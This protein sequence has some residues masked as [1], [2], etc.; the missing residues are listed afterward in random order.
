MNPRRKPPATA[1]SGWIEQLSQAGGIDLRRAAAL[2]DEA[3][4]FARASGLGSTLVRERDGQL[5][6]I[7][8]SPSQAAK[9]RNLRA[10]LEH[11]LTRAGWP[12]VAVVVKLHPTPRPTVVQP[13]IR[14]Q[15]LPV[16][17]IGEW[18]ALHETL[19][20]GPLKDAVARLLRHRRG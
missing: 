14:P 17:V 13:E 18:A 1:L 7:A 2:Q 10:S 4:R 16:T 8:A 19:E 20:A 5:V 9:M 6:W 11:Q 12:A 3:D 15:R